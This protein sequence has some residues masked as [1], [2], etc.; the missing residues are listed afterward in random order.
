[1][2][3]NDGTGGTPTFL[4]TRPRAASEAF[5]LELAAR[6]PDARIVVAPLMEIVPLDPPP[7]LAAAAG[8]IFTSANAVAQAEPGLGRP[9]W[10]V[11]ARTAEAA[12]AAGF[13][14]R[15]AGETADELVDALSGVRPDGLV[16]HLH[17]RHR[18]GHVAERLSAAGLRV[19]GAAVYDQRPV[20]P[21]SLLL[22]ALAAEVLCVPLF[23]P[24]SAELFAAAAGPVLGD[25]L[26]EGIGFVALSEAVRDALPATWRKAAV[27]AP[28][29]D[30]EAVLERIARRFFP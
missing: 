17:G 3:Y 2:A 29:P 18:R 13:D 26:R 27:V 16:V 15:M 19:E 30:A 11:G 1:M 28:R 6:W 25:G 22:D 9:A 4:L 10:C 23:S 8:L 14:A 20:A 21:D 7:G 5:A 24:R 12:R